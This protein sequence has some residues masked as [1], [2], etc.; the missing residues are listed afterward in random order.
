MDIAVITGP[1][2]GLGKVFAEKVCERYPD[3]DEVWLIARRND[4]LEQFAEE[5]PA[6]KIRPIALDLSLDSSYEVL[7]GILAEE[8]PDIRVFINNAGFN[9]MDRF[10]KAKKSDILSTINVNV[11]GM[12]MVNKVCLPY[13]SEGSFEIITGSVGSFAPLP[14]QAVYSGSKV[15]TRYF[16]VALREEMKKKGVN[17]MLLSPGNMKTDMYLNAAGDGAATNAKTDKLPFLDLDKVTDTAL[18]R[19]AS[20][21]GNYTPMLFF[22]G[23]RVLCKIVPS[24]LMAKIASVE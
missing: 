22:K 7:A 1:S 2:S 23:Y 14:G 18:A 16:A 19:A 5:H 3:L 20:G 21:K 10:D 17:V 6:A 12:T 24:A 11:K 9:K 4:R 13:L 8:K 15:Y